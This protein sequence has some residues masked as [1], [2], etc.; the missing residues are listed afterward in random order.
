MAYNLAINGVYWGYN[1]LT[2]HL[3]TFLGIQVRHEI[4]SS[5]KSHRPEGP[6]TSTL[7]KWVKLQLGMTRLW[8]VSPF[9][10]LKN[11]CWQKGSRIIFWAM[12]KKHLLLAMK[13]W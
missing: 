12:K 2:N 1:P 5:P 11:T 13:S 9:P 4:K 7:Q 6:G 8:G 10:S 3:P